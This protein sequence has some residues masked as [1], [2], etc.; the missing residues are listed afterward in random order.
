MK[1]T[2]VPKGGLQLPRL[3]LDDG[4]EL[5]PFPLRSGPDNEVPDEYWAVAKEHP[6]LARFVESGDLVEAGV[7]AAPAEVEVKPKATPSIP[8]NLDS[9]TAQDARDL[10]DGMDDAEVLSLWLK[11]EERKTVIRAIQKRL[12]ELND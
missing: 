11:D 4:T 9:M 3:R 6:V 5:G 12:E 2:C 8:P 7:S 10:V 1:L